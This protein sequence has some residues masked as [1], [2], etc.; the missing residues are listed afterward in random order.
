MV[1]IHVDAAVGIQFNLDIPEGIKNTLARELKAGVAEFVDWVTSKGT[2]GTYPQVQKVPVYLP[3]NYRYP[4]KEGRTNQLRRSLRASFRT[5][6]EP[7]IYWDT[8][9]A[10]HVMAHGRVRTPGTSAKWPTKLKH[11]YSMWLRHFLRKHLGRAVAERIHIHPE[12]DN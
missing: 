4:R 8:P 11:L 2:A 3:R 5:R 9:Y 6:F 10:S 12:A 1:T 7:D